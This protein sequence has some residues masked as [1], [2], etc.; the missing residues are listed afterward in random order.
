LL[1]ELEPEGVTELVALGPQ[2]L[3]LLAGKLQVGG[4]AGRARAGA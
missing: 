4:Q 3:D 2:L 1:A